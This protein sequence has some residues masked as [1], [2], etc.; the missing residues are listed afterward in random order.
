MTKSKSF[1]TYLK[2][3]GRGFETGM[4]FDSKPIFVGNFIHAREAKLW[5]RLLNRELRS[6]SRRYEKMPKSW[7]RH[8]M[9]NHLYKTYYAF[10]DRIFS[11]YTRD[12]GRAVV[13]DLRK[14]REHKRSYAKAA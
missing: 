3:V 1:K 8:F 13:K 14:W 10:L 12:Y 4:M 2:T 9:S 11:R 5:F 7:M 6:I